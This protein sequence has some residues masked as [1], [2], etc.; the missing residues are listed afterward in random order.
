MEN[1]KLE[2]ERINIENDLT[3]KKRRLR[4]RVTSKTREVRGK[5]Q[6]LKRGFKVTCEKVEWI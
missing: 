5:A 6:K 4:E 3:W 1:K 2:K